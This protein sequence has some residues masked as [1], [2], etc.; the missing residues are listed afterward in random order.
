M[1]Q[2]LLAFVLL[3]FVATITAQT[4]VGVKTNTPR[5]TL[6]VN[7]ST[8]ITGDLKIGTINDISNTDTYTFLMQESSNK[9]K[10]L[11][12]ANATV[13][14]SLGYFMKYRVKN[15]Q[16]D[17]LSDLDT[18]I[19]KTNFTVFVVSS[20]FEKVKNT[21]PDIRIIAAKGF[22]PPFVTAFISGT[23]WHLKADYPSI[24]T[25]NGQDGVWNIKILIISKDLLKT[26]LPE[27]PN[28]SGAST[29]VDASPALN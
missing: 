19:N 10:A 23:T 13:G 27:N 2:K 5:K 24:D 22:S 7:G 15:V 4:R 6:E 25:K 18:G 9:I 12:A 3:L 16:G 8:K 17:W 26:L 1:K 20:R 29:G 11:D 14:N 21:D 28:M